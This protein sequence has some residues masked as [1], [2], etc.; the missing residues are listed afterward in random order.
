M[1]SFEDPA[2]TFSVVAA[3]YLTTR[4]TDSPLTSS[5]SYQN[6]LLVRWWALFLLG[7]RGLMSCRLLCKAL[8]ELI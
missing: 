5:I 7:E 2:A 1:N 4:P 3:Y 8:V 6:S